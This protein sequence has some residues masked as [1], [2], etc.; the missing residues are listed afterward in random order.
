MRA[1]W[2]QNDCCSARVMNSASGH[3][4]LMG[5]DCSKPSPE[6]SFSLCPIKLNYSN[7]PRQIRLFIIIIIPIFTLVRKILVGDWLCKPLFFALCITYIGSLNLLDT[8]AKLKYAQ[9]L[10]CLTLFLNLFFN[11]CQSI[12][13]CRTLCSTL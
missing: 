5:Q 3:L 6:A 4:R 12:C 7:C 13:R 10:Q 1:L 11:F 2:G 8:G 9:I